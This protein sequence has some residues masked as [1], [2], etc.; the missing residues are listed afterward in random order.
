LAADKVVQELTPA[1]GCQDA[2]GLRDH[3]QNAQLKV[4]VRIHAFYHYS[5]A[6]VDQ[7]SQDEI[8]R[9]T[10]KLTRA[11]HL[12]PSFYRVTEA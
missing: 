2:Q 5:V 11:D 6:D 9:L 3:L 12:P 4:E 8:K 7:M 10:G 1:Q